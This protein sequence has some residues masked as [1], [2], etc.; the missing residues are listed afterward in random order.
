MK[1]IDTSSVIARPDSKPVAKPEPESV[2]DA[3]GSFP[4]PDESFEWGA[5]VEFAYD[6]PQP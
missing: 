5:W 2:C 3:V 6:L 4:A 1:F